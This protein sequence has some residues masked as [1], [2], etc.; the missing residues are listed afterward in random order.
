MSIHYCLHL[1]SQPNTQPVEN[2]N[3]H[4][5][6]V[7]LDGFCKA[8]INEKVKNDDVKYNGVFEAMTSSC[9]DLQEFWGNVHRERA[10]KRGMVPKVDYVSYICWYTGN[11]ISKRNV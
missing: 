4:S 5:G 3:H 7:L 11:K 1:F 8:L 9:I 2:R 6:I 10:T